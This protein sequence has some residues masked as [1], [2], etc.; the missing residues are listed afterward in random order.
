MR[1]TLEVSA[2]VLEFRF[3][4]VTWVVALLRCAMD[5]DFDLFDFGLLSFDLNDYSFS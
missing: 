1:G 5:N 4:F 3:G 2:R